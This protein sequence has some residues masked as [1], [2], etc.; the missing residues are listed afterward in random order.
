MDKLTTITNSGRKNNSLPF[1]ENFRRRPRQEKSTFRVLKSQTT[2]WGSCSSVLFLKRERSPP[3]LPSTVFLS[4]ARAIKSAHNKTI[5]DGRLGTTQSAPLSHPQTIRKVRD[6]SEESSELR[7]Q[8]I[9]PTF[10]TTVES[11]SSTI[12]SVFSDDAVCLALP[13]KLFSF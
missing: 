11:R 4:R 10:L 7:Q 13:Q 3:L 2:N 8:L 1:F 9:V 6:S 5:R 12:L